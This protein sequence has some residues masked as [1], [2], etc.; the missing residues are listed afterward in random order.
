MGA[1]VGWGFVSVLSGGGDAGSWT[2]SFPPSNIVA[3]TALS[4]IPPQGSYNGQEDYG[5]ITYVSE[6][7]VAGDSN[8]IYA[9]DAPVLAASDVTSITFWLQTYPGRSLTTPMQDLS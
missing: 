6:Y 2:I 8:P 1:Y 9:G 5:P 4:A 7:T 3:L